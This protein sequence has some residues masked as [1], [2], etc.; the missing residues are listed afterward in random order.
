MASNRRDYFKISLIIGQGVLSYADRMICIDKTA[1]LFS[2]PLIPYSWEATTSSQK[3]YFCVFTNDFL[4]GSDNLKSNPLFKIGGTP[5]FFPA[6]NSV[7]LITGVF[8]RMLEEINTDYVNKNSLLRSYVDVLVH[9]ALKLQPVNTFE[10]QTANNR[11]ASLFL[12]LLERQFPVDSRE[13]R[14]AI[15]HP[16][17]F[18]EHLS[19]HTNHL[20]RAIKET[21]GKPTSQVIAYRLVTEAKALLRHTDW[22]IAEIGYC[23]GFE[24]PAYFTNFFKKHTQTTPKK[25]RHTVVRNL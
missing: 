2:N 22:N 12:D 6:R 5:V 7:N 11:I 24:E 19:I 4:L 20:N 15:S 13:Y 14:L 10:K 17:A 23:L 21:M 1:L 8:E 25:Y 16:Q 9:Q 3:G 18:A